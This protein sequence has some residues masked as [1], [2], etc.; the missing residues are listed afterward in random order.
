MSLRRVSRRGLRERRTTSC[1]AP[2]N[3]RPSSAR[4]RNHQE[5]GSG[6]EGG[7]GG[8]EADGEGAERYSGGGG[9][10]E[11]EEEFRC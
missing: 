9:G 11:E 5:A 3:L 10:E 6:G 4:G 1:A 2:V 8:G 7:T